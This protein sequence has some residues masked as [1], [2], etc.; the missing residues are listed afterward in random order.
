MSAPG[1]AT[2][3]ELPSWT[4]P[5]SIEYEVALTPEPVPSLALNVTVIGALLGV[6]H[7]LFTGTV[8]LNVLLPLVHPRIGTPETAADE[9]ALLEPP[10][11]LMLNYGRNTFLVTL[12]AHVLYGILIASI[13]RL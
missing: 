11:F 2:I 12:A 10:G 5:P 7:A 3:A 9:I 4:L 8:L 6:L 1:A 13:V